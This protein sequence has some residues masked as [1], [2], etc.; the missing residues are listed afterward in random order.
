MYH[1]QILLSILITDTNYDDFKQKVN[2]TSSDISQW[3]NADQSVLNIK[4]TNIMK[5]SSINCAH[6]QLVIN[7]TIREVAEKS[8]WVCIQSYE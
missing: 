8:F 5:F 3:F 4:K 6:A 7:I 1:L 2:L